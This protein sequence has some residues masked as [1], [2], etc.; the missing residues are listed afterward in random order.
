MKKL[1]VL[2][3]LCAVCMG[4]AS[5]EQPN[6]I[7]DKPFEEVFPKGPESGYL[8]FDS[9]EEMF[10]WAAL[11]QTKANTKGFG[12]GKSLIGNLSG[13]I[14]ASQINGATYYATYSIVTKDEHAIRLYLTLG[15][16]ERAV[17]INK[18]YVQD[19]WH[20]SSNDFTHSYKL[21][22]LDFEVSYPVNYTTKK[23]HDYLGTVV[24]KEYVPSF[25]AEKFLLGMFA[26]TA[27][28]HGTGTLTGLQQAIIDAEVGKLDKDSTDIN[29]SVNGNGYAEFSY[30]YKNEK[31]HTRRIQVSDFSDTGYWRVWIKYNITPDTWTDYFDVTED[32]LFTMLRAFFV[33]VV[34]DVDVQANISKNRDGKKHTYNAAKRNEKLFMLVY[35]KDAYDN[36]KSVAERNLK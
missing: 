32:A 28:L 14:A 30:L 11:A 6:K 2:S 26:D 22:G 19:G 29:V 12:P 35:V 31:P 13:D 34:S 16:G 24:P 17:L 15:N 9:Q 18:F 3:V 8:I 23:A 36:A 7:K 1:I 10:D 33:P 21:S 4:C 5:L 27:A 25:D 20:Y